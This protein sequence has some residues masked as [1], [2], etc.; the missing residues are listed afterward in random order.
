MGHG[1]VDELLFVGVGAGH[2]CLAG[3]AKQHRLAI[4]LHQHVSGADL[5]ARQQHDFGVSQPPF[6]L[7]PYSSILACLSGRNK[8]KE[9]SFPW[10]GQAQGF[11]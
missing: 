11:R 1:Q 6:Q 2:T 4:K 8:A 7:S 10:H 5:D 3:G 9:G